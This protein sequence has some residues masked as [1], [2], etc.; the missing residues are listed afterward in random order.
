MEFIYKQTCIIRNVQIVV[1]GAVVLLL[2]LSY[3][4]GGRY[5]D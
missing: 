4:G 5:G 3:L 2:T 1:D